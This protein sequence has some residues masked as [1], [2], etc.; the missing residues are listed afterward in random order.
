MQIPVGRRAQA[1]PSCVPFLIAT[2]GLCG[3]LLSSATA[4][5]GGVPHL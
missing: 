4:A 2:L 5:G 3:E 1:W